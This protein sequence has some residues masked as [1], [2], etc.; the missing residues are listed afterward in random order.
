MTIP[1]HNT[2]HSN[3]SCLTEYAFQTYSTL[4]SKNIIQQSLTNTLV[5]KR[6]LLACNP[7]GQSN[8]LKGKK[9]ERLSLMAF[10]IHQF[11]ALQAEK[12]S[13]PILC[14]P[15]STKLILGHI[16][17]A[18]KG[19]K[20][21]KTRRD[22]LDNKKRSFSFQLRSVLK[23]FPLRALMSPAYKPVLCWTLPA[24]LTE[25]KPSLG[26]CFRKTPAWGPLVWE[27]NKH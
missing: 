21:T 20:W 15:Q 9:G 27:E 19:R 14:T 7:L 2:L 22:N 12:A 13:Q 10:Q 3:G 24:W 1:S 26:T 6:K 16:H 25:R 5:L 11:W 23:R 4:L 18:P 17:S 8:E